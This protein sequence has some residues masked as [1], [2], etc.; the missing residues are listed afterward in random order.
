LTK[1][2]RSIN[3]ILKR[4]FKWYLPVIA[5]IFG[6]MLAYCWYLSIRIDKRFSGRRWSIPSKVYSDTTILY[7]GQKINRVLFNE[8]LRNLGYRK[9]THTLEEKGELRISTSL[10]EIYLHDFKVPSRYKEGVPV[11]IRFDK[12]RITSIVNLNTGQPMSIL[13]LEPEEVMLFF[14]PKRERRRLVSIDQ[15]PMNVIHAVLAA[16]DHR[17]YEHKGLDPRGILRAIYT[18]LRHGSFKQ[19]GSTI[20]QQLAKNYFLTPKRTLIRKL[21]ELFMSLTMERMYNK[22]EILEI[23]LNEIYMGQNGSEAINGI[24]EAS[25][26]Y[27]GKPVEEL[28]LAEAAT[29]GGLIR[30]PNHYSPYVDKNRCRERRNVVL[31]AMYKQGWISDEEL[32]TTLP[33]PVK[34]VGYDAY[35]KKAPYFMDYLSDQLTAL[36][37][38]QDLSSLGLKIYTTLDTQV[39]TAAESALKK[40][41][42]TL[43]E[44]NPALSRTDPQKKLQGEIIVMQ[45]KTGYVLAMVGGRNYSVSQFNRITQARRQPGSAFK[46]FVYLSGLDQFTPA[47]ILSNKPVTYEFDGKEWTPKNYTPMAEKCVTVRDAL[48]KSINLA[49]VDLAMQVGIDHIVKTARSLGFSTPMK[50]YPSIALGSFEVIPLELA[51][52]YCPFAADGVLPFPLALKSVLDENGNIL[53][54][55]HMI[56]KEVMTPGKAFLM[57]SLLQSVVEKGTASSLRELGIAYPVAAKTG[58]TNDYRDAWFVG[59]TP[60]ILA[61]IWVGF[62]DGAPIYAT[63][64]KAALPIWADLM[65]ALPQYVSGGWFRMPQ[66]VVRGMICSEN[67]QTAAKDK[68][69][70]PM[71]EYFLADHIPEGYCPIYGHANSFERIINGIKGF[72][73]TF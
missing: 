53:E 20:T 65:N 40:G 60:D 35:R 18:D 8:K 3:I 31:N 59:Y 15:V 34:T 16:E 44:S 66:G 64:S 38:P 11:K 48:A 67:R 21:K 62:D 28:S 72:F 51:R 22:N 1:K 33:L 26:F 4:L 43:E 73:N 54:Q 50:P 58:T 36:Y 23:Y 41:L 42:E 71:E 12:N 57:S 25:I 17:F 49:T 37:S 39:Q 30:A 9:V 56:I 2:S 52:A 13:E 61:L 10:M 5:L 29:L 14:G 24:G 19:G 47:S 55:R 68:C 63:G 7:P 27:F 46:P 69:P 70:H 32:K 45:P 6:M